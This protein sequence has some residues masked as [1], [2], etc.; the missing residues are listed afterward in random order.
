MQTI[1]HIQ[2]AD[3]GVAAPHPPVSRR[4]RA[5]LRRDRR[6][7][8]PGRPERAVAEPQPL[9]ARESAASAATAEHVR[10]RFERLLV[11]TAGQ[12][13]EEDARTPHVHSLDREP[14]LHEWRIWCADPTT[15]P[16]R[17]TYRMLTEDGHVI[18]VDEETFLAG[19]AAAGLNSGTVRCLACGAYYLRPPGARRAP[20]DQLPAVRVVG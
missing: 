18:W 19:E 10:P 2:P 8:F 11:M 20:P 16:I 13:L 15:E 9:A 6:T 4:L 1:P 14:V 3:E 12:A 5:L 17:C 7:P